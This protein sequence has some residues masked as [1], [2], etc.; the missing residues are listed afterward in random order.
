MT[1][2]TNLTM[3]NMVISDCTANHSLKGITITNESN[4]VLFNC[5]QVYIQLVTIKYTHEHGGLV[6]FNVLG[7]FILNNVKCKIL[8]IG[9]ND[10]NYT[11][12]NMPLVKENEINVHKFQLVSHLPTDAYDWTRKLQ[13]SLFCSYSTDTQQEHVIE[14]AVKFDF[15]QT[16]FNVSVKLK[17]SNFKYL[18]EYKKILTFTLSTCLSNIQN[19]IYIE[20]CHFENNY[21]YY[22]LI[23]I[24]SLPCVTKNKREEK[25]S[26]IKVS[27]CEL[28][29][30]HNENPFLHGV[31]DI[32]DVNGF[33][34]ISE[35]FFENNFHYVLKFSS[36]I[37]QNSSVIITKS[38][39][40]AS[41]ESVSA[42]AV[43][44]SV[45][46]KLSFKGSVIFRGYGAMYLIETN[47]VITFLD[48]VEFSN[49][50][51]TNLIQGTTVHLVDNV[52]VN[53]TN[54][55]IKE[56][57]FSMM[58]YETNVFY[59]SCYFQ[60]YRKVQNHTTKQTI[61]MES[62]SLGNFFDNDTGNINCKWDPVS[63]Y[64]GSNPLD[65]YK[66]YLQTAYEHS[67]FNTGLLCYCPDKIQPNCY[68]N[69]LKS[70]F[71]GQT[72]ELYLALNPETGFKNSLPITVKMYHKD[73]PQSICT[74]STLFEAEQLIEKNCTK[75]VYSIF[76]ENR[77]QCKLI[78]YNTKY[79]YPTVYYINL[80]KCPA[81]FLFDV[82]HKKCVCDPMLKSEI[83]INNCNINDQTI[84]RP[85][86]SW[87]SATTHNNS[88]TY[89]VSLHCPF[90]YCLPHSSHLNFSTPNSQCQFSRS[91]LLCGHCQQGLSTVFGSSHCQHCSN[92]YISLTIVIAIA[93][94]VLVFL[95]FL[96]NLTV[97]DG[98]T[99]AFIFYVNMISMN[100]TIV[101]PNLDRFT[102]AYTFISLANLDLGIQTCFYNGMDD[103]AKMWLQLAFPFYLIFIATLIIIT[104]H[105]SITI[106]RLTAR[107][108]LSVLATLFLL[109]YTKILRI[110]SSVL[111]F[112]S[113]ITHLPSKHTTLVWSVDPN[114]PLFAIRFTILFIVCLILLLMLI[115]FN[116]ALLLNK[117]SPK[118]SLVIKFRSLFGFYK[119][120]YKN[121]VY[122]WTSLQ[123]VLRIIFYGIS[124]LE[125][126]SN[127]AVSIIL[128]SVIEG[129]HCAIKPFRNRI[130]NYQ[131]LFFM[132]NALWLYAYILFNQ[133]INMLI[134]NVMIGMAVIHFAIII[135]YHIIT[136][137]YGGVIIHKVWRNFI[138]LAGWITDKYTLKSATD[139]VVGQ[140]H[141]N[142]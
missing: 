71:P 106:Q 17:N 101:F 40:S 6:A 67:P 83:S 103:Y 32:K 7:K 78:L 132:L 34:E 38:Y 18:T 94:I 117:I 10:S 36:V 9:Y 28:I 5:F 48:Y 75:L 12:L 43:I 74:V 52:Y 70:L 88:Y 73:F 105:Y 111:F 77:Q 3:R 61:L 85:A 114:V 112:Y 100:S 16:S 49:N 20:R 139:R 104:S 19:I 23:S 138:K 42:I 93:G 142:N 121:K 127:L 76:S 47:T 25:N 58:I 60:H 81:G 35:C 108:A 107:R 95:M 134:V 99:N 69:I 87:I 64:Y 126:N 56:T 89:Y 33:L 22:Y 55:H 91:G 53:I 44:E 65:V 2:I 37:L 125:R 63:M 13:H 131:E 54:N 79:K 39:L 45:N 59:P 31:I 86:N 113:T 102:P 8:K 119:A 4:V 80:L 124:C 30:N 116:I 109:S 14:F 72:L 133:N 57:M 66:S 128:L 96:L 137:A 29:N 15:L 1:N 26:I 41:V 130:L 11:N 84:L 141:I 21:P 129:V 110:V 122:Y 62:N 123:L 136:Y 98:T 90:H 92:V 118:F 115:L 82:N 51:V 97:V 27:N 24:N 140:T 120:P 135:M 46:V 50:K 68:T